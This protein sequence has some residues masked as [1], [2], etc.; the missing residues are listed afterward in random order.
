MTTGRRIAYLGPPGTFTEEAALRYEPLAERIPVL[1]VRAVGD[2]VASGKAA[3]GVVPIENSLE[4]SVTDTLDL[5]THQSG[6]FI[7][8]ELVLAIEHCLLGNPDVPMSQLEVV[9]SHPQALGQCRRF[10][11]SKL[12]GVQTVAALSTVAGVDAMQKSSRPSAAIAPQRAAALYNV[13]V[14]AQAIQ[15]SQVNLTRFVVL[16]GNDHGPTGRDKTSLC[17]TFE[18]D[19]PG[20]LLSVLGEFAQRNINLAKVES[21]PTGEGLGQYIFLIDLEGHKETTMIKEALSDIRSQVKELKVF[22]SYPRF[23]DYSEQPPNR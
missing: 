23:D 8:H 1:S 4:G 5:L 10:L 6:L 14:L 21:R 15:D 18:N 9:Y 2:A 12:P 13:T 20:L 7:R 16:A 22:G 17:F 3:D 11:E 19:R